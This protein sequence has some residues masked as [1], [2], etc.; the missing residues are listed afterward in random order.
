M[1]RNS[2]STIFYLSE[3]KYGKSINKEDFSSW[4]GQKPTPGHSRIS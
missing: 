4:V 2:I 3:I 1:T